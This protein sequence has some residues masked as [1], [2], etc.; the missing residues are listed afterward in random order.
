MP[1]F[2]YL[3]EQANP[4]HIFIHHERVYTPFVKFLREV[5]R[6]PSPFTQAERELIASYTSGLNGCDYCHNT[7]LST[8]KALGVEPAVLESMMANVDAAPVDEKMRAILRF[9]KKL[10]EQPARIVAAD[11]NAVREAGWDDQAIHDAIAVCGV[12]NYMNRLVSGHGVELGES[13]RDEA[14]TLVLKFGYRL[15]SRWNPVARYIM[16]KKMNV[17]ARG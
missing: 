7:H 9:V 3:P 17:I 13:G 11:L 14:G 4:A 1:F 8:A 6:G 15:P 12:F 5:M 10:T 2:D 16:K